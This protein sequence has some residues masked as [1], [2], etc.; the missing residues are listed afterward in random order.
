VVLPRIGEERLARRLEL[1]ERFEQE[2]GSGLEMQH[3]KCLVP[4]QN[5]L[6]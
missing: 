4:N 1:G 6:G 3:L 5:T 2:L